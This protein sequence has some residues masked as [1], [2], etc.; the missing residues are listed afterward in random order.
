MR[1]LALFWSMRTCMWAFL[2]AS[3]PHPT[4]HSTHGIPHDTAALVCLCLC[5]ARLYWGTDPNTAQG[6]VRSPA[7][8]L[9]SANSPYRRP[10]AP[11]RRRPWHIARSAAPAAAAAAH[12]KGV[13]LCLQR[14]ALARLA[15]LARHGRPW[16]MGARPRVCCGRTERGTK[17]VRLRARTHARTP[18]C[19]GTRACVRV[20]MLCRLL[21]VQGAC[22][23][24]C[25]S[26]NMRECMS[27][28]ACV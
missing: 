22:V 15:A 10:R 20:R 28:G 23:R 26:A 6:R 11:P 3:F 8:S 27:V 16:P 14:A 2:L 5:D 4:R 17:A 12:R 9:P 21:L 7:C 13:R 1:I 24:A 25:A 18:V 19:A